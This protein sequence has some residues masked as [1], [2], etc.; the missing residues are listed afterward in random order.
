[1]QRTRIACR[2]VTV[3]GVCRLSAYVTRR[4]C[5]VTIQGA[6]RG[7]PDVLRPVRATP[8]Y[9]KDV[10]ALLCTLWIRRTGWKQNGRANWY[11]TRRT[12]TMH[13]RLLNYSTVGTSEN[14]TTNFVMY[15]LTNRLKF[16]KLVRLFH[17]PNVCRRLR[18]GMPMQLFQL[19]RLSC[20]T[21]RV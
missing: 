6:A 17:I 20:T 15:S 3:A 1:M 21:G 8:C 12:G 13:H 18:R 7:G 9:C 5:N 11:Q 10:W 2:L 19:L 4:I 14:S 16:R